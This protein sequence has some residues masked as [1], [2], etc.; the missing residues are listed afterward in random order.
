MNSAPI[1]IQDEKYLELKKLAEN[2][3]RVMLIGL[4]GIGKTEIILSIAKEL[5]LKLLYFSAP[6]IDPW[7]D[8]VGIPVPKW[9][10]ELQRM[11]MHF[12]QREDLQNAEWIVFDEIN[13]AHPKTQNGLLEIAQFQSV[14]GIPLRGKPFVWAGMNPPDVEVMYH[15]NEL[16]PALQDR[17]HEFIEMKANPL[18]DV[19]ENKGIPRKIAEKVI[20]WY[21]G[22][23]A[24]MKLYVTPRRLEYIMKDYIAGLDI[25][26]CI[27]PTRMMPGVSKEI[28][29]GALKQTLA[30]T[31]TTE[32]VN[33]KLKNYS[34]DWIVKNYDLAVRMTTTSDASILAENIKK[35]NFQDLEKITPILKK[36]KKEFQFTVFQKFSE[37]LE[38]KHDKMKVKYPNLVAWGIE[39]RKDMN[40]SVASS[41]TNSNA[42]AST[43]SNPIT[44]A[45]TPH[46]EDFV[47]SEEVSEEDPI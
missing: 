40:A 9:N 10:E 43:P 35:F 19:Y 31:G 4:H 7:C 1:T 13:R 34:P 25:A 26:R 18:V 32:E 6:T 33:V 28:P 3:R 45:A 46:V 5:G 47:D 16:D 21:E 44:G 39:I 14:N 29:I 38:K 37:Q 8:L 23:G 11:E 27:I 12:V 42:P 36:F 22:L 2:K 24:S 17:F 41:G 15:V 20:A 30:F